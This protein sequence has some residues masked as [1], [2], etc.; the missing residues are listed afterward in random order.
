MNENHFTE[1][2]FRFKELALYLS[3][4][5]FLPYENSFTYLLSTNKLGLYL[6]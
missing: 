1:K 6:L 5:F 2:Y 3:V 4:H